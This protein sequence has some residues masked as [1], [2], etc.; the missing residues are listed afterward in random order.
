MLENYINGWNDR[1]VESERTSVEWRN[2]HTTTANTNG[3]LNYAQL[4]LKGGHNTWI[5]PLDS[6]CDAQTYIQ[7]YALL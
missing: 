1:S 7:N 5:D 4:N 3:N 6:K 2:K